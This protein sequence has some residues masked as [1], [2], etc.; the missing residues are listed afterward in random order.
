MVWV[1]V[2]AVV[3]LLGGGYLFLL[4]REV[5]R[6]GGRLLREVDEAVTRAEQAARAGAP[7]PPPGT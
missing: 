5:V 3:A 1:V 4:G 6:K 7:D 2:C